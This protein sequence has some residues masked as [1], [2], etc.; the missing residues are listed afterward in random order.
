MNVLLLTQ[1]L[2]YPPDSGPKVK[3]YNVLKYLTQHHDVTLASFV[4]GDQSRDVD[5]L[6]PFCAGGVHVVQ[7]AR[8]AVRDGAA[9]V[10]SL[11]TGQ[12]WMMVRDDRAAMR[13]L[14]DRLV[15][16]MR[17]DVAHA[18][19]LNM[20]QYAARVPGARKVL[21]A[22]NALWLLYKR[23][24]QTMSGGPRKWLLNR[25]WKLL[26]RYEGR[27]CHDFDGVLA[28]SHEDRTALLE[29]VVAATGRAADADADK[30]IV[31]PIAVD[32][33]EVRPVQRHPNADHILHIGTMYWPPNIDGV[34]WFIAEVLPHIRRERPDVVFDV[35]G[36]RPPQELLDMSKADPR[37]NVTGYVEDPTPYLQ[38][39]GV[40][41][42]PLR[43][44]GGMRVKILNAMAQAL[45][46]VTTTL[47]C[48]GIAVEHGRHVLI[49]DS[50]ADFARATLQ[51]L[52]DR[53]GADVLGRNGRALIESVYDYR[54]AC[55]PLERLYR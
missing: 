24:A 54:A 18:D 25:D 35:V 52:A 13:D 41:V 38:Q 51:V 37:I 10:R 1:V 44:G 14:V 23:L 47:G 16:E 15:R 5:R 26:K 6:R 2:P 20:A 42:V 53:A 17:F 46:I 8:G 43:A 50:P 40:M 4:R 27:V 45:P 9:M 22:H 33:D 55:R 21:D 28:V 11:T 19:Q 3:T 7:M 48:E 39:A 36:A 31:I 32:S 29:A 34:K 30:M 49:A 12:P